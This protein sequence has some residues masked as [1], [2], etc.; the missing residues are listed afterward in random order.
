MKDPGALLQDL[1]R[2]RSI[3][4]DHNPAGDDGAVDLVQSWAQALGFAVTRFDRNRTSNFYA[5]L[6]SDG[7]NFCFA[8]HVDVVPPGEGWTHDP[9]GAEIEDG[10]LYGRGA[11]DM[12]GGVACAVAAIAR[13][14]EKGPPKGSLSLV[15][16]GDE[17][18]TADDGTRYIL[19][20][21]AARNER[22]DYCLVAEPSSL[23]QVGD[24]MKIGRRGS[25]TAN[26]VVK[27]VQAH[28]AYPHLAD[29]PVPKIAAM[30]SALAGARLDEG[31]GAFP[32]STLAFTNLAAGVGAANVTPG[33][34][35]LQ[36][37]IRFNT[38]HDPESLERWIRG[39]LA[40]WEPFEMT[41]HCSALP[42]YTQPGT[43]TRLAANAIATETGQ[44]VELSTAG[45]TSDARYMAKFCSQTIELGPCNA[46]MHKIDEC[47]SLADLETVTRIYE[48]ILE[49]LSDGLPHPGFMT[50]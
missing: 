38:L 26:I 41:I 7:P 9:F 14:L 1:I 4:P 33:S 6:G 11:V 15:I 47:V 27:G 36:F 50:T 40:M 37:N 39:A 49:G 48:R 44:T 20:E 16:T 46:T 35:S 42:F 18:G 19:E 13:V 43:L 34:A 12:K 31:H 23:N 32:P 25:L 24:S 45:G 10:V 8:G 17:E 5:R 30:I 3:T 28:A 29:N 2:R 22:I 21:L